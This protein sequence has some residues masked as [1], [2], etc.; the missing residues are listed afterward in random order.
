MRE[1]TKP[2]FVIFCTDQQRAD[3][4]GCAGNERARTPHI[5]SLA[6]RGTRFTRHRT[7]NQIC[8]PS[9]GSLLTGL[10][11][12]HHGMTTNGR[13]MAEEL[14][15]LPGLLSDAGWDTHAVGKLHLQPIMADASHRFPESVPFWQAG[16][17]EDWNGPYFGYRTVAFMIGESCLATQGG[18]YAKWLR[19]SYPDIIPLYQPEAAL[20]GPLED[21]EEAWTAA[22][23]EEQHYNTWI[24][25]RAVDFLKRAKPPFLLFVSSP[26]PHHPF[27]PPRP[28]AD[29]FNADDMPLPDIVSGELDRL[30]PYVKETLSMDWIDNDAAAVEQ[31]GM[32]TTD[33]I[34]DASIKRAIAL[35]RGM[36]SMIDDGCGKVLAELERQGYVDETVVLFTSDHGE[37]LGQHGLLHKGPPPFRDLSEV[38]FIA[39]GPGIPAGQTCDALTSHVD[40][41]PTLLDMAGMDYASIT[42]DGCSLRPLFDGTAEA[43]SALYM[44][45]HP[46]IRE[47]TYNHSILTR[48]R[49]LTLYPFEPSWGELFDL[50]ADP[51]E[52][53]NVFDEPGYKLDRDRLADRLNRE[54]PTMAEA[55]EPLLA[56]W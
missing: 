26:D 6:A 42:L 23:P 32:T 35:T 14:P 1:V 4:L 37:F 48:D 51:G 39:A 54:F 3:S 29:L 12:R 27:S 2:S 15:T 52:H 49:R 9:R 5:D 38:A 25:D 44:E 41:L 55:G 10:Y 13:T 30:A 24:A 50:E 56:K 17:G 8:C 7:P 28:W 16:L 18:H 21:L 11:P 36:E 40:I 53:R 47:E 34:S 33:A 19:E 31:G 22:V 20:E 43:R 45:Y 46:R